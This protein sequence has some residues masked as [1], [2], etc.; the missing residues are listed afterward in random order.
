MVDLTRTLDTFKKEAE[1][2]SEILY[3]HDDTNKKVKEQLMNDEIYVLLVLL[4]HTINKRVHLK[5]MQESEEAREIYET[6]SNR[7]TVFNKTLDTTE[8]GF[9]R[10]KL[11]DAIAKLSKVME[12][13][14]DKI[15]PEKEFE[16]IS[17]I[18]FLRLYNL[19]RKELLISCLEM[20]QSDTIEALKNQLQ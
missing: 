5:K 14:K 2:L 7:R 11:K 12:K 10:E 19:D 3:V 4:V 8:S 6:A 18:K 20:T 17:L 1:S 15:K 16:S 9:G 13:Q